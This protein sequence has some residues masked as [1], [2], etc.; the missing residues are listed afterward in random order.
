MF[1][2]FF[3]RI[4]MRQAKYIT[5]FSIAVIA[6]GSC[7]KDFLNQYPQGS[8]NIT[9][10]YKTTTDFQEALVG[11]YTPLRDASIYAFYMEEM[12]SDNT[13]FDYNTKD[14]GSLATEQVSY[15]LDNASTGVNYNVWAA[16]FNGIQRVN[17][18]LSR[19]PAATAVPDSIKNLITG[20][21]KALRAHYYFELV[22][23]FGP[24]PLVLTETK[25]ISDTRVT[26]TT[27]D[28]VYAQ[29]ESDLT[30]ALSKVALP[31]FNTAGFQSGRVTRGMIA[32]EL[33]AMYLTRKQYAKAS[34]IL[35]TVTT[36][37]YNLMPN[38]AD[39]FT[40]ANENNKEC[41]FE[42]DFKSGTDGQ[43]SNFIYRFIPATTVTTAILGVNYN[44]NT[45]NY[46]GWNVPTQ[47]L[48]NAYEPNDKRLDASV[49]V[50]KGHFDKDKYFIADSVTSV[51][52]P[53]PANDSTKYFIRKF[54]HPP[55]PAIRYNTDQDWYVYR[56]ADVLLM[57][58]ESL[59]EQGLTGDALPYL[60]KV[61]NRAGLADVTVTDQAV[62]RDTIAHERRV[63]LAFENKRWFDLVRTDKA[64]DVMTAY[65]IKQKATYS[66]LPASS[67]N[68]T[69]NKM[70]YA[71]P[72]RENQLNPAGLWQNPGY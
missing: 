50:T 62:V 68:V 43:S 38:Y 20:E 11:A 29:I 17:V 6:L 19:L 22:R 61:R 55:Y 31:T 58:A 2:H 14:R 25:S 10:F 7:K 49:A 45:N 16:D 67:Y 34:A 47:D 15:F 35:G 41:I 9:N 60:N 30:D 66:F 32:T 27:V 46:G 64:I 36:M 57:L 56:Y 51:L 3:K 59:N 1:Y 37:G 72:F 18:I 33:G 70:I 52:N 63:E 53:H 4:I 5:I 44:N 23:L 40:T 69:T 48:V 39:I 71:I 42:I 21:A 8:I 54:Y 24:L 12:R 26:R 13:F 65:G 28:S